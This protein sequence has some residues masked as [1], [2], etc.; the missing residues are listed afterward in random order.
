M[1]VAMTPLQMVCLASILVFGTKSLV[2]GSS[3]ALI[4]TETS[5]IFH[6]GKIHGM[7]YNMIKPRVDSIILSY[8]S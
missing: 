1:S 2:L 8:I 3:M 6:E 4:P 7:N 5:S